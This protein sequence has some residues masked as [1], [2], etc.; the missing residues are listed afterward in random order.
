MDLLQQTKGL[1][2][3]GTSL[4]L[5]KLSNGE[6]SLNNLNK[7]GSS[8]VLTTTRLLFDLFICQSFKSMFIPLFKFTIP[9]AFSD[10]EPEKS[11]FL[12]VC[13]SLYKR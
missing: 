1:N 3:G 12:Q 10:R 13:I 7:K 8:M 9:T 4:P 2:L 11:T 5:A 6:S